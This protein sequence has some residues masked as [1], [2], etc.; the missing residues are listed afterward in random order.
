MFR[1]LRRRLRKFSAEP[2]CAVLKTIFTQAVVCMMV[3]V[4][5]FSYTHF[6]NPDGVAAMSDGGLREIGVFDKDK[7]YTPSTERYL[8]EA[9]S[10]MA[11]Q[12]PFKSAVLP[13]AGNVLSG[14]GLRTDPFTGE[15]AMHNGVDIPADEGTPVYAVL[16]GVVTECASTEIAGN[17][18]VVLHQ[19]GYST[20]YGHL[21]TAIAK[22]GDSVR[23]GQRIAL[24]G[25]TGQTT[26]P[27]L[28]FGVLNAQRPVDPETYFYFH[29]N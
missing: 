10:V 6:N 13:L 17:Y 18:I 5:V 14:Y 7:T 11:K 2:A 3:L 15:N 8:G 26:G 21:Q 29:E 16:D 9:V 12:N 20:Y 22:V 1:F 27:H 19:N 28:H 25:N 24:S 23:G 4:C